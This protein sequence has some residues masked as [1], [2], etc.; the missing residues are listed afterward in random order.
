[1]AAPWGYVEMLEAIADPAPER[2]DEICEWLG[3]EYDPKAFNAAAREA[4]VA[5]LK[6]AVFPL[7]CGLRRMLTILDLAPIEVGEPRMKQHGFLDLVLGLL[8]QPRLARLQRR[9][10]VLH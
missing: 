1:L 2:H 4:E 10:F 3:E 5:A 7:N 6:D 8:D 9:H